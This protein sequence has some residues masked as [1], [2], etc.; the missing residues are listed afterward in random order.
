MT[1][2]FAQRRARAL[3]Q[4]GPD[5]ILLLAAAPELVIG[6]DTHL[7]YVVDAELY[8]L[9]GYTEPGAVLLLD[10]ASA[11]PFTMFVRARD[12]EHELWHGRRGGV[13]AARERFAAQAAHPVA[14]LPEK[15]PGLLARAET[16]FARPTNRPEIDA[17]IQQLFAV[18]RNARARTG[19]GPHILREPGDI[20][21]EMRLVKD[22]QEVA[23]LREAARIS[24]ESFLETLP[25]IRPGMRESDVEALLEYG[26]RRRGASGPAF[27]TIAAAGLNATVLHYVDNT[28]RLEAGALL[29]LDAGARYQMYCGDISRTVPV[30]GRF[31]SDQRVWYDVVLAAHA[32]AIA[33]A[34]PGAPFDAVHNAAREVLL[35]GMLSQGLLTDA[36]LADES[37]FKRFYP[38]RTSHWLGLE[39]HDVGPY[40][41]ADGPLLLQPGMVLTIEPGLYMPDRTTGVRIEDDVLIT[42]Q[43]PEI[44]TGMLPSNADD[45]EALLQ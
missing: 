25:Q 38:H 4:L 20:L 2:V 35:A 41:R 32:A 14:E 34:Q 6:R 40:Q 45:I 33:A 11:A 28:A 16:V 19:R 1:D 39:V 7:R 22:E 29:L 43:G 30:S 15:L 13:E 21:D 26:F 37:N 10:P 9:T 5:G 23:L 36:E 24:A 27:T 18:G 8:Y 42:A 44:L 3:E 12:A 31:S 17:V